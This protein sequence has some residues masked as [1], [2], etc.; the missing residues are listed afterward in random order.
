M[1]LK[2][3]IPHIRQEIEKNQTE[4]PHISSRYNWSRLD[5]VCPYCGK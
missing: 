5:G 4:C 3:D 2:E 1:E